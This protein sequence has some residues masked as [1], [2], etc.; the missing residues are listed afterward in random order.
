MLRGKLLNCLDSTGPR[1]DGNLESTHQI[2]VVF[3]PDWIEHFNKQISDEY[4]RLRLLFTL[5]LPLFWVLRLTTHL[6]WVSEDLYWLG[7]SVR[8]K[9]GDGFQFI[10]TNLILA[11]SLNMYSVGKWIRMY[12]SNICVRHNMRKMSV[13]SSYYSTERGL[14]TGGSF[15]VVGHVNVWT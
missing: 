5:K 14:R 1:I 2:V 3:F 6:H 7:W 4:R 13:S 12:C 8:K 10:L 15:S 9:I 11:P